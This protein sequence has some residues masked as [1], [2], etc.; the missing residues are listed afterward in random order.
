MQIKVDPENPGKNYPLDA[1]SGALKPEWRRLFQDFP[2]RF[3]I[4]TDQHY[5]MPAAGLQRWQAAVLLLNQ[6]PAGIREKI[7][8]GNARK[9]YR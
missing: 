7:A 3:L 2:E 8:G 6:L 1:V 4:G 9:I 5:P